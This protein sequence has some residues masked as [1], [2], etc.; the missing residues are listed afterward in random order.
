MTTWGLRAQALAIVRS[1]Q[2]RSPEKHLHDRRGSALDHSSMARA[3]SLE[4]KSD[5]SLNFVFDAMVI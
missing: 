5:T 4:L 1:C 3:W 2:T